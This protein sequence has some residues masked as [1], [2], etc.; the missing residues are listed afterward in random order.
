MDFEHNEAQASHSLK[1]TLPLT[2]EEICPEE[3]GLDSEVSPIQDLLAMMILFDT[4]NKSDAD[5][6][7]YSPA[8]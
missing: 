6:C 2:C 1:E 4:R 3:V 5:E 8:A 7:E